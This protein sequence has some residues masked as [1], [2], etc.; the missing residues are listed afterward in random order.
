MNNLT[1]SAIAVIILMMLACAFAAVSDDSEGEVKEIELSPDD[2]SKTLDSAI[3]DGTYTSDSEVVIT[4]ETG[5]YTYTGAAY[6]IFKGM[7]LTIQAAEGAD[8]SITLDPATSSNPAIGTAVNTGGTTLVFNGVQFK[9]DT[10]FSRL[11]VYNFY[12]ITFEDCTFTDTILFRQSGATPDST[13]NG[14]FTV[15]GC[16]FVRSGTDASSSYAATIIASS[17]IFTD[18]KVDGYSRGPNL[19]VKDGDGSIV[20]SGNEISNLTHGAKPIAFQIS[21]DVGDRHAV[22]SDN[23]INGGFGISLY[24]GLDVTTGSIQL[25]GNTFNGCEYDV[26][27]PCDTEND[28]PKAQKFSTPL[29]FM[30]NTFSHD[31]ASKDS[32]AYG[33]E[34]IVA[35]DETENSPCEAEDLTAIESVVEV[36]EL[37]WYAPGSTMTISTEAELRQFAAMV[38]SGIDFAGE[39]V[40]LGNDIALTQGTWIPIGNG[41]RDASPNVTNTFAGTFIGNGNTVSGLSV[42]GYNP[43]GP[44]LNDDGTYLFGLFGYLSGDAEVS[45]LAIEDY[46][47]E[48]ADEADSPKADSIAALAGF[49]YGNVKISDITV[50][51]GTISGYD[52]VGGILARSYG[53]SVTITGCVNNADVKATSETGGKAG[54][55]IG[56]ISND[57][58]D[59]CASSITNSSS[60]GDSSAYYAGGIVG[61]AN[62]SIGIHNISNCSVTGI[63]VSSDGIA[64]GIVA[65][66]AVGVTVDTCTVSEST[67]TG[68]GNAGGIVGTNG[69][70]TN[71]LKVNDCDVSGSTITAVNNAGGMIGSTIG[72]D[73]D[74]IGGSVSGTTIK[75]TSTT[76]QS[77]AGGVIG[78]VSSDQDTKV[79]LIIDSVDVSDDVIMGSSNSDYVANERVHYSVTEATAVAFMGGHGT[80]KISNM[81]DFGDY[82]LVSQ[83]SVLSVGNEDDGITEESAIVLSGVSTNNI[84]G[85]MIQGATPVLSIED[86]SKLAGLQIDTQ[87]IKL[88][89]DDTSSIGQLIAGADAERSK[90]IEDACNFTGDTNYHGTFL[91]ASGQTVTVGTAYEEPETTYTDDGTRRYY[92]EILGED[93]TSSLVVTEGNEQ[94]AKGIYS[95]D[96]ASSEWKTAVVSVEGADGAVTYHTNLTDAL[97]NAEESDVVTLM[98]NVSTTPVTI[99]NGITLDLGDNVL[100]IIPGTTG[101]VQQAGILLTGGESKILNGT[102]KDSRDTLVTEGYSAISATGKGTTL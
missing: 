78:S 91:I 79:D 1:K 60:A 62:A 19:N 12:D 53:E 25:V 51:T 4:L 70:T 59:A 54:G 67:I 5:D 65:R 81:S 3:S 97:D 27:Y 64:G 15:T 68:G 99:S 58:V 48:A 31:G 40:Q 76:E 49:A 100:T 2:T 93:S 92:G 39:R 38:N 16:E 80:F 87:T 33:K 71:T 89:M 26:F 24:Y 72:K 83:S 41:N 36:T 61:I 63:T 11:D 8:V 9:P 29:E 44:S 23:T 84:I 77:L 6:N 22:F 10:G 30:G 37:S 86:G 28:I 20:V 52:A 82:E 74:V 66:S 98:D 102:I 18:N 96:E 32:P 46:E 75:A 95:W 101:E 85:W 17:I 90:E 43:T 34:E 13:Q 88:K 45:G 47:L 21:G 94:F 73:I 56:I 14:S 57:G 55:I 50:G 35:G 42:E 7:S 69:G